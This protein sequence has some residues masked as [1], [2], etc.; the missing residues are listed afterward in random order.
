MD[1]VVKYWQ[2]IVFILGVGY[3]AVIRFNH[4][5]HVDER[6]KEI[7]AR[8]EKMEDRINGLEADTAYLKGRTNGKA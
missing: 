4:L 5:A 2:Q 1:F 6:L 8:L 7:C 3:T